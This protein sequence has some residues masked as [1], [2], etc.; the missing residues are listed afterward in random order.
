MSKLFELYVLGLLKDRFGKQ[1]NFQ[2]NGNYGYLDFLLCSDNLKMITDAK[3]KHRYSEEYKSADIRQISGY[4]R[5]KAI[6]DKLKVSYETVIDCLI[7]YPDQNAQEELSESLKS[8]EIHQF[9]HFFK[10]PVKLPV[11]KAGY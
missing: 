7:I 10:L 3:Y 8:E 6:L 5:D 2:V 4:A 11:V 9:A 1:L